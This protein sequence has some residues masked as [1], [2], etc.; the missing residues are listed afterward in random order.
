[1]H[2]TIKI[3]TVAVGVFLLSANFFPIGVVGEVAT[4]WS[5]PP[6]VLQQTNPIE[7]SVL[8]EWGP[9]VVRSTR[10]IISLGIL[11]ISTNIY[12]SGLPDWPSSIIF[13]LSK[14]FTLV[15]FWHILL[16]AGLL[17]SMTV[18]L[19]AHFT[20]KQRYFLLLLL[21]SDWMFLFYKKALGATE[22]LLQLSW[23]LCI[24]A[25]LLFTQKKDGSKYLGWGIGL[26]ILAKIT[27][28][29]NVI[30]IAVA[31][32]FLKPKE[33]QLSKIVLPIGLCLIPIVGTL[34][35]FSGFD[36]IVL[37]HDF[38]AL[39]WERII[40]VFN[41]GSSASRESFWN[42]IYWAIDPLPFFTVAY[43]VSP[44]SMNWLWKTV[45]WGIAFF[46]LISGLHHT[47]V[48]VLSL[49]LMAQVFAI[50]LIAKDLHHLAMA[51]PTLAIWLVCL[52][53][54]LTMKSTLLLLSPWI[55]GN[56]QILSNS[57]SVIN[58]VQTPTFSEKSQTELVQILRENKVQSV[59]TMDYE[60]Y[61]VLEVLAPDI[62]VTHSWAAI[63]HERSGALQRLLQYSSGRHLI[64]VRSSSGMIYNLR[65]SFQKLTTLAKE[66][67]LD[68]QQ[69][70][71]VEDQLW[72]YKITPK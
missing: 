19:R 48:K 5:A 30:P 16:A 42:I 29:L 45:G 49:V 64:V 58:Q 22:M 13:Y 24:V 9:I 41:N 61:G 66:I 43:K 34:V 71:I 11:P 62:E 63:S 46:F 44:V 14:S 40:A 54:N 26:G 59:V 52:S 27:F 39:Q 17:V 56:V 50:G 6:Q 3:V 23:V 35:V 68:V 38:F 25:V 4:A 72:L 57:S 18:L 1:M 21:A 36:I 28:V 60:I 31:W 69:V 53:E 2:E 37:S 51:T 47:K 10:P 55:L 12:T 32:F 15:V 33:Y 8:L 20:E 65:P 70:S 67:D 7:T